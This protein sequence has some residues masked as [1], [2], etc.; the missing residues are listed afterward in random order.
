M[1]SRLKGENDGMWDARLLSDTSVAVA[2]IQ[3]AND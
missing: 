1:D 3:S 2:P